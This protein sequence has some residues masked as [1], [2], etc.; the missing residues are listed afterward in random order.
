MTSLERARLV[1]DYL[2][3]EAEVHRASLGT[4]VALILLA[5]YAARLGPGSSLAAHS[6]LWLGMILLPMLLRV[7]SP[8]GTQTIFHLDL[9]AFPLNA[10]LLGFIAFLEASRLPRLDL[11]GVP[12][13]RWLFPIL[14]LA[15]PLSYLFLGLADWIRRMK[16][17][18][19]IKD[20][21]AV[22]PVDAY[23]EEP[24]R[25]LGDALGA[26]PAT[27]DAWAQFRTVPA[28]AKNLRLFFKLDTA[29]HGHWRVAFADDYALVV[30]HDG[31]EC[32]AVAPGGMNLAVDD[33]PRPGERERMILVRWNAHFHEGRITRD[34]LL[35]IQA[36][37]S[38]SAGFEPKSVVPATG[39]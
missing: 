7:L 20:I 8:K 12:A 27:A 18:G 39:L 22:P 1:A 10:L 29:R 34:D 9:F 37:N 35:K 5:I 32:E 33:A 11:P 24:R 21:L 16:L 23:Q 25:L 38:R 28:S 36:W 3:A 6:G 13:T 17:N 30:F 4:L 19:W 15:L 14:S 26:P 2:R 31:A